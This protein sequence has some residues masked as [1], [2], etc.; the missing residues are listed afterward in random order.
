LFEEKDAF[1]VTEF[2]FYCAREG[3]LVRNR[4][5]L[6]DFFA[7]LVRASRWMLAPRNR[8]QVIP[9]VAK[10]THQSPDILASY[11]LL[12]GED[13]YRD[14]NLRPDV[15]ALQKNLDAMQEL[16]FIKSKVDAAKYIELSYLDAAIRRV[17]QEK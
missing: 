2:A 10:L 15:P 11:Y 12:K 16:G 14:P 13:D 3:W 7:D 9:M 1:G 8:D 17:D 5:A 6:A 4:A